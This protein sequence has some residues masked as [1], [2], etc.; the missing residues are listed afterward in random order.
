MAVPADLHALILSDVL[1]DDL[2]AIASGP[3]VPDNTTYA[4][5]IEILKNKGIWD[6]VPASIRQHL[7]QGKL[8]H[9]AETPKPGDEI[10]KNTGH[11]LIG[12]NAI[13]VNAMLASRPEAGLRN[14]TVQRAFVR[15]SQGGG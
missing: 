10:F 6:Q 12:S 4:D 14:Q 1:G 13:S 7:E 8:G 11:T 3:T 5:A 15:R 2:S 9:I